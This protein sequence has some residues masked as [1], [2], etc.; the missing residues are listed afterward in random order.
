V[1]TKNEIKLVELDGREGRNLFSFYKTDKEISNFNYDSGE[2]KIWFLESDGLG[3]N[4]LKE[5]IFPETVG[6]FSNI[7][8]K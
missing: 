3:G 7:M 8:G 4:K 2:K 6:Y 1:A 5:I